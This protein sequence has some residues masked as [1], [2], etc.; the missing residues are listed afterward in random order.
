MEY[1]KVPKKIVITGDIDRGKTYL[2]QADSQLNILQNQMRFQDLQ[3][4][5]R[6][7]KLADDVVV[8]CWSC[9]SLSA[10]HIHVVPGAGK[11]AEKKE[12]KECFCFCNVAVAIVTEA[13]DGADD[14]D[15]VPDQD[16][17]YSVSVCSE[18]RY[19]AYEDI[20]SLDFFP[21]TVGDIVLVLVKDDVDTELPGIDSCSWGQWCISSVQCPEM[22]EW[23]WKR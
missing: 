14:A 4:G 20:K 22:Q 18:N 5:S 1:R 11:E 21:H 7:V 17:V 6:T 12:E 15:Y 23:K 19:V 10:V 2:G 3:Q 9:F 8:E 16:A 13:P